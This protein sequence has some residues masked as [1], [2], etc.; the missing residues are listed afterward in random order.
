M[1]DGKTGQKSR[2][3]VHSQAHPNGP[4]PPPRPDWIPQV[5][6]PPGT[7]ARPE[8]PKPI[9]GAPVRKKLFVLPGVCVGCRL[10][11]LA[12]SLAHEGVI[13]PYQARIRVT[14]IR[15]AGVAEPTICRHC[16]PAPCAQACPTQ[17]L[18]PSPEDPKMVLWD[19]EKCNQCYS[20]M[21]ACRFGALHIDPHGGILKCDMCGGD[22]AC[23]AVC[24]DRPEFR[25]ADW[26]G[27]KLSALAFIEPQDA[28]RLK[29]LL[30]L[31]RR[32]PVKNNEE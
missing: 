9:A 8:A 6:P 25:P 4:V 22:P 5:V 2:I 29:R 20:C 24:Q 26:H 23:A 32:T 13:N 11:E 31:L 17:A 21:D 28:G 27:G 14:Q 16:S 7:K 19:K 30:R 15:E 18:S 10:C 3:K 1:A 12:C